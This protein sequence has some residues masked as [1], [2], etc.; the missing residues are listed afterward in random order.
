M[1]FC[2]ESIDTV[3]KH[4]AKVLEEAELSVINFFAMS[5][6]QSK[7]NQLFIVD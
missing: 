6:C 3:G 4:F 2:L 1:H 7:Y 5:D